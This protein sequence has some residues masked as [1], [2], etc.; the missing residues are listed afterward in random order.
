MSFTELYTLE[1]G[2]VE[3]QER[4]PS[5]KYPFTTH[6]IGLPAIIRYTA[7]KEILTEEFWV[8]GKKHRL[9]GP[10]VIHY[11][12]NGIQKEYWL[13]NRMLSLEEYE[14]ELLKIRLTLL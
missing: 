8:M 3:Y 7:N 1:Y 5:D 10:A 12:E 13:N 9:D 14:A 2:L 11:S 4:Y 6:R